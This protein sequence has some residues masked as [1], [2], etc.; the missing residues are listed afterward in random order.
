MKLI[1]KAHDSNPPTIHIFTPWLLLPTVSK[2]RGKVHDDYLLG[3]DVIDYSEKG[4]VK[5]TTSTIEHIM[6]MLADLPA[7]MSGP[8]VSSTSS[9]RF[10]V[11][12]NAENWAA[13][14]QTF[15][16]QLCHQVDIPMRAGA[17]R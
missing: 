15:S 7:D 2:L 16:S 6:G 11:N 4:K 3:M 9:H 10:D 12:D 8:V 17:A 1:C 5:F 13:S 14:W